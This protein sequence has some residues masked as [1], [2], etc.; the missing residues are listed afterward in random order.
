MAYTIKQVEQITKV[1][2]HTLRYWAK[3]GLFSHIDRDDNGYRWFSE[4]D[5]Q[6]V[7]LAQCMRETGMSIA[8]VREF[9]ELCKLGDASLSERIKMLQEQRGEILNTLNAYNKALDCLDKKIETLTQKN[10]NLM[11]VGK[12]K[13]LKSYYDKDR[14]Y[15][16]LKDSAS[17]KL[18]VKKKS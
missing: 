1:S 2:A 6:W 18:K 9:V 13:E 14:H 8:K 3:M 11:S 15:E 17:A 4:R 12:S 16:S 7:G 10:A 5:L